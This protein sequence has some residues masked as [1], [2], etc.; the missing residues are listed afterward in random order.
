M[1]VRYTLECLPEDI[2]IRG[3]AMASGNDAEDRRVEDWI[4]AELER[5]NPWA[6]C[7]VRV[8]AWAG[9]VF[10][11]DNLGACSYTSREEFEKPGGY[12]DDMKMVA[13]DDLREKLAKAS[14]EVGS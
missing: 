6:W 7:H 9:D 10:G 13:L 2:P 1:S 4:F 3:N 14:A 5:G 11:E 12:F 8:R